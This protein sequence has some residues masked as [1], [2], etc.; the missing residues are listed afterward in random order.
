MSHAR[1]CS[2]ERGASAV[3]YGL[4][5]TGIAAVVAAAV[6]ALGQVSGHQ[7]SQA[8]HEIT[9]Q[10]TTALTNAGSTGTAPDCGP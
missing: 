8:C 9:G 5:A 2:S 10:I 6:Y 3:E 7:T 1:P 4:L